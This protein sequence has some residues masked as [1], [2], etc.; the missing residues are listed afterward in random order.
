MKRAT[1]SLRGRRSKGKGKGKGIRTRDHTSPKAAKLNSAGYPI[2]RKQTGQTVLLVFVFF[3]LSIFYFYSAFDEANKV[4]KPS[5]LCFGHGY[6]SDF[7]SN[8]AACA[9]V[10]VI[11]IIIII[12]NTY[13]AHNSI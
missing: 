8:T 13:R 6:K 4:R 9:H 7:L 1:S 12:F 3:V 10:C 11:I 5:E 2:K